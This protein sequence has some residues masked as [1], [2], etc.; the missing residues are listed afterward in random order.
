MV[1][2]FVEEDLYGCYSKV[3]EKY[4]IAEGIVSEHSVLV[5]SQDID[6]HLIVCNKN[7]LQSF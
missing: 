6:P 5:G 1:V 2:P 3:I 4:F 7:L